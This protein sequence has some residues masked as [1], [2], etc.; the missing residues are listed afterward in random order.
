MLCVIHCGI[1]VPSCQIHCG[2]HPPKCVVHCGVHVPKIDDLACSACRISPL[3]GPAV[4]ALRRAKDSGLVTSS[5]WQGLLN[6]AIY[7]VFEVNALAGLIAMACGDCLT[8]E[9]FG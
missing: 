9:V 2:I 5:D 7:S 1:H 6:I 3:W 8:K 4:E